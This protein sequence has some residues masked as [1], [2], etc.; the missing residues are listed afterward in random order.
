MIGKA[1][2]V[3]FLRW[4]KEEKLRGEMVNEKGTFLD[5]TDHVL[6]FAC[7]HYNTLHH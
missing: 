7:F 6:H 4:T 5:N 3:K 2:M 1:K